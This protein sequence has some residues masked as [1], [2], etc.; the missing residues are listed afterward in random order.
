M[1]TTST[2]T[3]DIET[4]RQLRRLAKQWNVSEPAALRRVVRKAAEEAL[5]NCDERLIALERLQ[6]LLELDQASVRA[7]E[8]RMKRERLAAAE[9]IPR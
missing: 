8:C 7:W 1:N 3:L 6:S 9:R 4:A 2:H 5:A